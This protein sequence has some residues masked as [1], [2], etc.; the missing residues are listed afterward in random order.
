MSLTEKIRTVWDIIKIHKYSTFA[1]I[2]ITVLLAFLEVVGVGMILPLM[3]IIVDPDNAYTGFTK[4]FM[5]VLQHIDK[6]YWVLSILGLLLFFTLLKGLLAIFQ[7][8]YSELY[9][10]RYHKQWIRTLMKKNMYAEYSFI[11]SQKQG[12]I[13]NS[14]MTEPNKASGVLRNLL[15]LFSIIVLS[16]FFYAFLMII[17]W[18]VT[19]IITI[20]VLGIELLTKKLYAYIK[21]AGERRLDLQ[22]NAISLLSEN[23]ACIRQVKVFS[24]ENKTYQR[25]I[26]KWD[27]IIRIFIEVAVIKVTP[28]VLIELVMVAC[29]VSFLLIINYLKN[30]SFIDILPALTVFILLGKK[31]ST[32]FAQISKTRLA[33]NFALPSMKLMHT[34]CNEDVAME[35]LDQGKVINRLSGD[36]VFRDI[37]FSY[38]KSIPFIKGMNIRFP[39]GKRTA[40][41]GPSGSGKS[42][43]VDLLF[44]LFKHD[45][46]EILINGIDLKNI[47][48][49][50]WRSLAGYVSQEVVLFNASIGDNIL[51]GAPDA[52][53]EDIIS[54]AK[55]AHAD[56]FINKLPKGYDTH[57]A[58]RGL[59]LSGGQ[60]QRIAIA[61]A[62][63]RDPELYIFDEATSSLDLESEK[64]IQESINDLSKDKTVIIITHR[65]QS[66]KNSDIIY[67][68]D[69]GRI[70]ESGTYKELEKNNNHFFRMANI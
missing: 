50:S 42:T 51:I 68:L 14:L 36:I 44:G 18:Q 60:R 39:A 11:I 2:I 43:I 28:Y 53:E 17:N 32:Q 8:G 15:Q 38:D 56:E 55:K 26:K 64:L 49:R 16:L 45:H 57:I 10:R 24:L 52:S 58:E 65:L 69:N 19:L 13:I 59:K 23:I 5:P 21:N 37:H 20:L 29:V 25:F 40:I 63:I 34:L 22:R 54:A 47:N 61:R 35:D 7:A 4:Y 6:D 1:L 41:V 48:L 12:N 33:I 67:F 9:S 46:G 70:L 27:S 3:E 62:I 30:I 31:L 66:V